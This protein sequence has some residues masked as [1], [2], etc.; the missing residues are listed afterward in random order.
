MNNEEIEKLEEAWLQ[1]DQVECPLTHHFAPGVYLRE[2]FMPQGAFVIGAEHKTEH[3]NI[4]LKGRVL[5]AI[6][7]EVKAIEAPYTF[8]SGPGI[9]K[10]LY[11]VED[12]IWQTIHPT[13]E[14]D[15]QKLEDLL[16]VK[17]PTFEKFVKQKQ[18]LDQEKLSLTRKGE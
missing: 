12:T 17:S 1:V 11:I 15:L 16:V 13:N 9:R 7:D 2:I 8:I 14:K 6:H 5:V 4:V 18:L 10:M 3:L